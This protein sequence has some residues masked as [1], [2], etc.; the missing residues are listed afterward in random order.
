VAG[1]VQVEDGLSEKLSGT[2]VPWQLKLE[3]AGEGE[4]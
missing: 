2:D 4:T 1:K 3:R